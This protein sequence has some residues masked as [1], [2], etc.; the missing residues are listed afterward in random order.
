MSEN[1]QCDMTDLMSKNTD[2]WEYAAELLRQLIEK[3]M[4]DHPGDRYVFEI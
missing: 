1:I 2:S 3:Y 4:T